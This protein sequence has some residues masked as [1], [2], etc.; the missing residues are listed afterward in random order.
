[1]PEPI[2][3]SEFFD[4]ASLA[5]QFL[6]FRQINPF[7]ILLLEYVTLAEIVLLGTNDAAHEYQ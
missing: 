5:Y 4:A 6:A 3:C 7:N 1:M 2:V